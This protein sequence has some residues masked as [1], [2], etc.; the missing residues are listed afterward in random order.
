MSQSDPQGRD[1]LKRFPTF[2]STAVLRKHWFIPIPFAEG[3]TMAKAIHTMIRVFDEDKS[4]DFYRKAFG[5][6]VA[7]RAC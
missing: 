2:D 5:L 1:Q 6:E 4:V 3:R 7:D